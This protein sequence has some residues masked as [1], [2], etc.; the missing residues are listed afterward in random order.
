MAPL[1][2]H[3]VYI[4]GFR[5]DETTFQAF[6]KHLQEHLSNRIPPG[7]D[8][9]IQT[10]IYPTYKSAKPIA[11]AT[12][13]FL[14]WLNT[15]P[16]GC[17]I[18]LGH[19]MGGLLAAEAATDPSNNSY[20]K[21]Q[22]IIGMIA[23]DCPYL[24]MH[25]HVVVSGIAS[26]FAKKE[27]E[28][29]T[30]KTESELNQHPGVKIANKKV[31]DDW[32]TFK[33]N[34]E[35]F[36]S[37][38]SLTPSQSF[39]STSTRSSSSLL[40]PTS[41]SLSSSVSPSHSPSSAPK[42]YKR[43]LNFLT[44]H[45][46]DPVVRWLRKHSDEPFTA[47]KRWVVEHFQFGICMFDPTGLKE[48]YTR[49]V[50][51]NGLWTNYWTITVPGSK[52]EPNESGAVHANT[53][54]ES[55]EEALQRRQLVA[56][57]DVALIEA[58]MS[59][60]GTMNPTAVT[61]SHQQRAGSA[62]TESSANS[63]IS[64]SSLTSNMSSLSISNHN[65][66]DEHL[67]AEE[68]RQKAKEM[69]RLKKERKAEAKALAK[70]EKAKVGRHFIV[71]PNGLGAALGGWEKWEKVTIAGVDDEVGAHTGLFIPSQ[72]VEYEGLV[73]RVGTRILEWCQKT[74]GS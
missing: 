44:E 42:F 1:L 4:H 65:E 58:G 31:T 64:T 12:K 35:A 48:R 7:L 11:H 5:G 24:G 62:A 19:S 15:Q 47:S 43:T 63:F 74:H 66:S 29:Q 36:S 6:P 21:P 72:N 70:A 3:L 55:A 60:G 17:V 28:N 32:E 67:T 27:Q 39:L 26:L 59:D 16:P 51:W 52:G 38:S 9:Q 45:A 10:T 18:L 30:Q 71:L 8:V 69:Q 46:D 61:Q 73:E 53:D 20:Q 41:P 23:F 50:A 13:N 57:N 25:P 37:R 2:V 14:E 34:P 56:E 22:R 68:R 40:S 33:Q 49:L 54:V